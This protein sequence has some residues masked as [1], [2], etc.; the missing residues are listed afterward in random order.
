VL[1]VRA[2]FGA[3]GDGTLGRRWAR[4]P[5]ERISWE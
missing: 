2:S 4:E 5:V 1:W 3:D